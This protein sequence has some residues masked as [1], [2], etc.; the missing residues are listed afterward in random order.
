MT[1]PKLAREPMLLGYREASE[2]SGLPEWLIRKAVW[3]NRLSS[4]HPN[5]PTGRTFVRR[6]DLMT[7]I[8]A[9]RK[10]S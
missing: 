8:E 2:L 7:F 9:S 10:P 6:D 4:F 1:K 3:E 5:G